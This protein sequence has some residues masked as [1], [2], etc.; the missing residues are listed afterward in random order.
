MGE[1]WTW[2]CGDVEGNGFVKCDD[3]DEKTWIQNDWK[4]L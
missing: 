3:D 4:V 2:N 1:A